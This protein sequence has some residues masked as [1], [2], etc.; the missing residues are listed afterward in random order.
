MLFAGSTG[1]GKT[2]TAK[3]LATNLFVNKNNFIFIDMSE[4]ADKTAVNKLIG[5]NPGYIG[6]D[7]GGVLTE[8]VRKN[9]YSLILFDEIQ[10]ADEE[11][12]FLLLQILEEGKLSDSSGKTIDFSNSIIV[13][14][15]NVGAQAVNN[16]SIGFVTA[17]NSI[18]TDVLSSV[19]KYFPPDLL[20]R[21]DEIVVFNP[22]Q[23]SQIKVIIEK[24]MNQ[25][26]KEL[27]AKNIDIDYS[28]EVIMY[29]F[30]KIQFD[31]FGARQVIKTI[32]REI[33][34][35]IAEKIL[36]NK[37]ICNIKISVKDNNICVT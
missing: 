4:Y 10:K 14:T 32:Q 29:V 21:L 1:I 30:K 3:L 22:L 7:K 24:E 20:N 15:T 18:K 28:E 33:Q 26:K 35:L 37:E 12:L 5:S 23:E 11:V 16:N 2:M 27:S 36:E 13:M 6:Y 19:K 34:T 8:K 25:F 31:N 17:K 9:P